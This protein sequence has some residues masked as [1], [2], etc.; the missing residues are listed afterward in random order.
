MN[1][2]QAYQIDL[3]DYLCAFDYSPKK[4][5]REHHWYLSPFSIMKLIFQITFL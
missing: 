2:E 5:R 4:I 1:C 3:V